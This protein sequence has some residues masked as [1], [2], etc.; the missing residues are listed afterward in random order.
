MFM[1]EMK[2]FNLEPAASKK[3]LEA[4]GWHHDLGE[5]LPALRASIEL[6]VKLNGPWRHRTTAKVSNSLPRPTAWRAGARE[7]AKKC[8]CAKYFHVSSGANSSP[9]RM[10]NAS[11]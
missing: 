5:V 8:E 6:V 4:Q 10:K 9:P 7:Q 1:A 2:V 3:A 11:P